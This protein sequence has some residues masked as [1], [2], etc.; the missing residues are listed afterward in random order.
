MPEYS[1]TSPLPPWL[2]SDYNGALRAADAGRAVALWGW[3]ASRRDHG[4]LIFIDLR[5]YQGIVQL[6]FNPERDPA[7]HAVAEKAR[8]EY[9]L[10]V[11][12]T[13][14]RRSENT[15]NRE[16]PTGEVEVVVT[17]AQILASSAPPPFP[18]V[19]GSEAAS[20]ELR[21]RYR[22]LDLRRAEMQSNLRRRHQALRGVRAW[23]D[24]QGFVEIETPI[25][26]KATPE[27][28]RDYLVPSRVNPGK[29]YAL[30]QSPQ[31]LKQL[32]MVSGFDRY[33]QIARCFRDEDLRANRQPEFSQIDIEMTGATVAGIT[34][35]AEGM[36]ASAFEYAAGIKLVPP[37]PR[38]AY[39]EAME[40]FGSD[41]PDLRFAMELK[42]LSAAFAGTSFKVFADALGRGDAIYGLALPGACQ[43][44]RRELDEM[45]ANMHT[46]RERGLTWA[47]ATADGNWQGPIARH[48]GETER[49]RAAAAAGLEPNGTLLLMA[50]AA[51]EIRP[52][53]GDLRLQLAEK[54][55]LRDDALHFLWVVD[56]PLFEYSA[57]ER[58]LVSVNHP[59]TAPHPDDLALLERE[60]LKVRALAYDMVLNGQEMGGGSIRIHD[61]ELQLLALKLLGFERDEAMR[62]FGFLIEALNYGAPPHGGIAFGVDRLAM[63]LCG[64]ESLRDVMAFP[65]TQKAV[66]PMSGAPSE[67][68]ARQLRELSIKVTL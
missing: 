42:N 5:D 51:D 3:V 33:Y 30:P 34:A 25:L 6:V 29:F 62:R 53:L 36:M 32:L 43:L 56:F 18:L 49:A 37:F 4:G 31:L 26:W 38:I 15:I 52:A 41:K 67:V 24:G 1:T 22:Y 66:D 7:A 11:K 61:P 19:A 45:V 65:K 59:F 12:G 57:E 8:A 21:L 50:G 35:I 20:E 14:V 23:L 48:I 13:V 27:G 60:P 2:R 44:S 47:K 9:Y 46:Q 10:A 39:S 28:A 54:F 68:D 40:R 64:T 55:D 16:L 63:M 17:E 58:R